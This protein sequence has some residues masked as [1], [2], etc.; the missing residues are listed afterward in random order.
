LGKNK[1]LGFWRDTHLKVFGE[2]VY[3]LQDIFLSDWHFLTKQVLDEDE[4]FPKFGDCGKTTM[5]IAASGPD[6]DW[7]ALLQAYFTMI[8]TA[9]DRIWITTPYLVPEES[10]KMGL[11][12]AALSGVD[13]RILI[14]SKPDHFFVYW[15]SQDNIQELLEA[16]VK[17]YHYKKGFIHGK[18]LLVDGI[19]AS[20]GTANLDIRSLEINFE[21]NAFIYDAEVVKRLEQ[22]F[23]QDLQESEQ[24]HL[25][26][27]VN[28][29]FKNKLLEAFGRLVSPIQ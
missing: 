9:E 3:S 18:I 1:Y 7:K 26:D 8:S 20:V 24:I 14:P 11:I 2:G 13:V 19:G 6:S 23:Y 5:Q 27:F 4:M 17:V 29:P 25:A 28:R 16:G 12:T 15:A 10:I 22:D 21:I